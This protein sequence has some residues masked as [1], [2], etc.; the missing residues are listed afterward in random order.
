MK[1]VLITGASSGIGL[2]LAKDYALKQY[3]VITCG[4]DHNKIFQALYLYPAKIY[5]FDMTPPQKNMW[6][7]FFISKCKLL[8]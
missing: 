1:T 2:Q 7:E 3:Q 4:R 8:K 6:V 5:T